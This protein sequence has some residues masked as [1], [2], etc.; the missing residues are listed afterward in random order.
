[1]SPCQVCGAENYPP[2]MGGPGICP[3]CDCGHSASPR[4][5]RE[6]REEN[7]RLRTEVIRLLH[8]L[9]AQDRIA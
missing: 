6:L 5:Y 4:H 7:E 8:K 3:A 9:A 2:S 1:M